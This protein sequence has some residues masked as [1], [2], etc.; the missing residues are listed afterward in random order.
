M[1]IWEIIRAIVVCTAVVM[2]VHNTVESIQEEKEARRKDEMVIEAIKRL[3]RDRKE[4]NPHAMAER[5][6]TEMKLFK[7]V[8]IGGRFEYRGSVYIKLN[9]N[10]ARIAG[11]SHPTAIFGPEGRVKAYKEDN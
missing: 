2:I 10:Q 11:L 3:E 9:N 8:K 1:N 6:E 5:P 7:D 4:K